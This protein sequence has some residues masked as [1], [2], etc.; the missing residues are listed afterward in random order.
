M[1]RKLLMIGGLASLT[2][3]LSADPALA[4]AQLG[5][6]NS[7]T[8]PGQANAVQNCE[9]NFEKQEANGQTGS[10]TGSANDEKQRNAAVTNCDHFWDLAGSNP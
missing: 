7:G 10:Q 8:A 6:G 3:A 9:K 5:A 2:L 1:R 4:Y